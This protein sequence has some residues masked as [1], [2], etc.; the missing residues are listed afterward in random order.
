MTNADRLRLMSNEELVAL[1]VWGRTDDTIEV[2][3]CDEGCKDFKT[4]C[5]SD[6]PYEKQERAVREWLQREV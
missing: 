2:P 6:C 1:L 3:A 4:G 5:A